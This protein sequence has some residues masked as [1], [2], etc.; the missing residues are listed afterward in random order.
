V[1]RSFERERVRFSLA[2][3]A[4]GV[5]RIRFRA[6]G[7]IVFAS[8]DGPDVKLDSPILLASIREA[9][10]KYGLAVAVTDG[11]QAWDLNIVL[12]PAIRVPLNALRMSEGTIALAW[13]TT[14]EA[15]RT[16]I[17]MPAIFLVLIAAGM[18]WTASIFATA[19]I[20]AVALAPA[21]LRLRR[22][23]SILNAA[24]E[25]IAKTESLKVVVAAGEIP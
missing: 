9:L 12:T 7:R 17:A 8:V 20:I 4:Y 10:V 21:I 14:V 11:F 13:K 6:R 22:V 23:P 5:A 3:Q 19:A 16:L 1:V 24:A 15:R 2:P 25:S 18:T